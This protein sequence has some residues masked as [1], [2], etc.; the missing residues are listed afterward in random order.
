MMP[1][2]AITTLVASACFF[3]GSTLLAHADQSEKE[4]LKKCELSICQLIV[5]KNPDGGN[6]ACDLTKTWGQK[7][8]QKGASQSKFKW[9]WGDAK[10]STK[11]DLDRAPLLKALGDP[12]HD[13]RMD[14][15]KVECTIGGDK[16]STIS[17]TLAPALHFEKGAV[18]TAQL[19]IDNIKGSMMKKIM[20]KSA[21]LLDK[22]KVLDGVIA[23]E[24]NK[25]I[26]VK[27]PAKIK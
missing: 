26:T 20:L 14:P 3:V 12:A 24:I 19:N 11:I 23:K 10:C 15:T 16:A 22:S 13:L 2:K 18:T 4:N 7:A 5:K 27:C 9:I 25:F 8:L 1:I 21:Q 17:F 6:V